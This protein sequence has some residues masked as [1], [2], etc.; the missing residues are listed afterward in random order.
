MVQTTKAHQEGVVSGDLQ[1]YS[2]LMTTLS[3]K[4]QELLNGRR[5]AVEELGAAHE[6]LE[7]VEAKYAEEL[8]A[9]RRKL[10]DA[11]N[12]ATSAG[13]TD[14]ELRV[15][16]VQRPTARRGGRS[17]GPRAKRKST[18]QGAAASTAGPAGTG[19]EV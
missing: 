4:A 6:E 10:S 9:A 2:R 17:A 12:A 13:W 1:M 14:R 19:E 15:L 3:E 11:Y 16:G 18:L 5:H 7:A 8:A